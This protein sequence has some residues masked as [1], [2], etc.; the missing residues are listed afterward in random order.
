MRYTR[1]SADC[2]IDMPWLPP[3]LF[4]AN[5][6]ALMKDRMP[7]VVEG[8]DGPQWTTKKGAPF[9]LVGGIGST[10]TKY[11]PGQN[12]RVDV[13]ASTG[14]YDDGTKGIRRPGDPHLRLADM[15]RDGVQAEVLFG[16]LGA[17]TRLGDHEAAG[18]MFRIYNDWLVEFCKH[19]PER[20]IGLA[21]LPYGNLAAAV[22]EIYRVARPGLPGLERSCARDMGPMWHPLWEPPWQARTGVEPP[23]SLPT[24]AAPVPGDLPV[25]SDRHQAD[26][27]NGRR[28]ADV[29]LRLSASRRRLAAVV[30]VHPGAVRPPAANRHPQ[31]HVRERGQVLRLDELA[32]HERE[33]LPGPRRARRGAD[34]HVGDDDPHP[35]GVDAA[36]GGRP[37][38]RTDRH[39]ALAVLD[40][41]GGR[42]GGTRAGARLSDGRPTAR[43]QP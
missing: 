11:V 39:G 16:I 14:L 30:E 15:D 13:M 1:I 2:H 21:C 33:R 36:Q 19:Y 7:Y 3:D 27:R 24:L 40:R 31:D 32:G 17:A 34:R 43:G 37:R 4:P 20:H 9:G 22:K 18:E 23:Q 42:H 38:F 35:R 12:H 41:D 5:A 28:D 6:S 26:R 10:G 25:R 8:P 29:G